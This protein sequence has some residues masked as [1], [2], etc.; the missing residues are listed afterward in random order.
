MGKTA[1]LATN[2]GASASSAVIV[3]SVRESAL[4]V[5][6]ALALIMLLALV[7]YDKRDPGFSNTGDGS[8]L[9][10]QIGSVGAWFADISYYL[11][12]VP[13]YLFPAMIMLAGW[14]VFS[15]RGTGEPLDRSLLFTRFGG[16]ALALVTSCGLAMALLK[17]SNGVAAS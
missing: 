13:A 6:G 5:L 15:A 14:L 2:S 9:H 8:E 11:C 12:G 4:W 16:F 7:T 1:K 10:N 3:R 17:L